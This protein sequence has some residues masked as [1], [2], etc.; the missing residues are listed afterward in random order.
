M[1]YILRMRLLPWP[2]NNH[3]FDMLCGIREEIWKPHFKDDTTL[4][5]CI[6]MSHPLVKDIGALYRIRYRRFRFLQGLRVRL[7][8]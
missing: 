1:E 6:N 5:L 7:A 4:V 3:I 2:M 8:R